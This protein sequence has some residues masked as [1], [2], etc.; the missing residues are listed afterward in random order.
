MLYA[1]PVH[2]SLVQQGSGLRRHLALRPGAHYRF[3]EYWL[4]SVGAAYDISPVDDTDKR[5]PDLPLDRQIHIGHGIQYDWHEDVT[6]GV[7]HEYLDAGEA[8]ID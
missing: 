8:E 2:R 7:A 4:W 3:A 6:V 1:E 5:M